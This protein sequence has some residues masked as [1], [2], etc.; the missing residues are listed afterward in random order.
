[1]QVQVRRAAET[2]GYDPGDLTPAQR[3]R[4]ISSLENPH[5]AIE[6]AARHLRDLKD[7]TA[8]ARKEP[9]RMTPEEGGELAARYNGGPYWRGPQAQSYAQRYERDLPKA[10]DAL[11]G[12]PA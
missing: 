12:G 3:G 6:I 9:G 2:L 1:M 4:I 10:I 11:Y 8:F 7:E 5:Q